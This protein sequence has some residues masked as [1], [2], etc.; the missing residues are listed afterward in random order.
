MHKQQISG[1]Y[2]NFQMEPLA[3]PRPPHAPTCPPPPPWCPGGHMPSQNLAWLIPA[4]LIGVSHLLKPSLAIPEPNYLILFQLLT[5]QPEITQLNPR[6]WV[7]TA[8]MGYP[9]CPVL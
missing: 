9:D 2:N 3:S 4:A 5:L 6:P 7:K 8:P 1:V